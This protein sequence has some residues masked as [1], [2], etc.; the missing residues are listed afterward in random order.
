MNA[1]EFDEGNMGFGL[2]RVVVG[3]VPIWRVDGDSEG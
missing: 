2:Q 1:R 3:K